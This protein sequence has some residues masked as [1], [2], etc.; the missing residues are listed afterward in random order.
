MAILDKFK[1]IPKKL[2]KRMIAQYFVKFSSHC[3]LQAFGSSYGSWTIDVSKNLNG[4]LLISGGLG[5]D[6]SF[7]LEFISNLAQKLFWLIQPI[8]RSNIFEIFSII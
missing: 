2:I 8:E 3:E 5:E 6:A 4:M 1:S 7:D